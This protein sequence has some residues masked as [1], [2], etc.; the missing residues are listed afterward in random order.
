MKVSYKW[1]QSFF[2]SAPDSGLPTPGILIETSNFKMVEIEGTEE[3]LGDTVIDLKILADRAAYMLCHR[4]VA[5]EFAATLDIKLKNRVIQEV[6]LSENVSAPKISIESELCR[7]YTARRVEGVNVGESPEWLRHALEK[8][9]Q[10]S[11]NNIVDLA[12]FVMFDIGQPL[13]A[14]DA[15][16]IDGD[17]VIRLARSDEQ[18]E[19]LDGKNIALKEGVLM[20]ADNLGPIAIAGVRGG[21]R[22]GITETTTNLIL[23]SANFNPGSVRKT[24]TSLSLR[25]DASKRF[26]NNLTADLCLEALENFSSLIA[27]AMP[28]AKFSSVTDKYI[29]PEKE[30]TV[31]IDPKIISERLG[32]DIPVSEQKKILL[33]MGLGVEEIGEKFSVTVP[34]YR[35]DLAIPEDFAEEIGRIWGYDKL[36]E[37]LP[38]P[39]SVKVN[40][41]Y[42]YTER[43]RNL[44]RGAGF[45]EV[46]LYSLVP[47]GELEAQLPLAEDKKCY[48]SNLSDGIQ[49]CL[50]QNRQNLVLLGGTSIDIFEI[51]HGFNEGKEKIRLGVGSTDGRRVKEALVAIQD[52]VGDGE[53]EE[54]ENII[55]LDWGVALAKLPEQESYDDLNLKLTTNP[56]IF[57]PYSQFPFVLRDIALWA[58]QAVS[59]QEVHSHILQNVGMLLVRVGLF[60]TFTKGDKTSYAFNLVFQSMDRT[61]TDT[62]VNEAMTGIAKALTNS[63]YVIR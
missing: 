11:V 29:K 63:G 46:Y 19:T 17:I 8:L 40:K 32:M 49:N 16:K 22:A 3:I 53:I 50:K 18:I 52:F 26:E 58:P 7:R 56:T 36:P 9:D 37:T 20:I 62:E 25:T 47:R 27:E 15:D 45:S 42:Y 35:R 12:N 13:H 34:T 60:D 43:L 39:V 4:G 23:E 48:R 33:R 28:T 21:K 5:R 51:G 38:A 6:K 10:R 61:L 1:L 44:L 24:S 31:I 2:E 54:K 57:K 14:F 41:E 59:A 55:E 30:Q